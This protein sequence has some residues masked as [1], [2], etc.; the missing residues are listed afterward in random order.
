MFPRDDRYR[1]NIL[2]VSQEQIDTMIERHN[3]VLPVRL[4]IRFPE[5]YVTDGSNKEI[6]SLLKNTQEH[7]RYHGIDSS[8]VV[9]R[10]QDTSLNPHYHG[11]LLLDGNK[12]QSPEG[13]KQVVSKKWKSV[14]GSEKDGLVD[15]CRHQPYHPLPALEMI[16]RP[17]SVAV[18]E[19]LERQEESFVKARQTALDH[20]DYLAK[21]RTKGN[22]PDGVRE[23]L[24]SRVSKR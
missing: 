17:S 16:R 1:D 9:V 8:Y 21:E 3:K 2:Q 6:Q 23:L 15:Y 12:C 18:E 13:V 10:E 11:L 14:V 4:D 7:Y 24:A 5:E 22:A 19:I 20:A